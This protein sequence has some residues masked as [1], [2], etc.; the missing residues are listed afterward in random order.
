MRS[1]VFSTSGTESGSSDPP[2]ELPW[3]VKKVKLP[4]FSGFDP[5]SWIQ[6]ANLYFDIN[7]AADDIHLHLVKLSMI[8][9]AQHWFTILTQV[10]PFLTWIEF[11]SKLLQCFSGLE[12]QNP[13]EQLAYAGEF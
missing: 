9:V 1:L 12:I 8:G 4:E 7:N 13:Y 6:K 10:R 5:Q 11:Q 3:A 2:S